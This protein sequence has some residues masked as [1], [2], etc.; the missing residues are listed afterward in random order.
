MQNSYDLAL[1][2]FPKREETSY[3]NETQKRLRV[4]YFVELLGV[5]IVVR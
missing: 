1:D 5:A 2:D 4:E 3:E